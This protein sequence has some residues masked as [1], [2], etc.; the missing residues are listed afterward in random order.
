MNRIVTVLA[1]G[2]ALAGCYESTIVSDTPP[3][4]DGGMPPPPP[5]P[6]V[7]LSTPAVSGGTVLVLSSQSLAVIGDSDHGAIFVF[8]VVSSNVRHRI[9]L[10]DGEDVGRLVEDGDGRVHAVLRRTGA[11]LDLEPASGT[12]VSTRQVCAEPRGIDWDSARDELVVAC[13]SG[14]LV[15]L[16]AGGG[17][18]TRVRLI[19]PDLRDVIADGDR[20][21]VSVF[22][23]AELLTLDANLNVIARRSPSTTSLS[24]PPAPI[25]TFVPNVAWRIRRAP[26]G[27]LMV[28]QRS[29]STPIDVGRDGYAAFGECMTGVVAPAVT[30]FPPD[31]EPAPS[32]VFQM[33]GLMV[34]GAISE[35]GQLYLAAAGIR[36]E[37]FPGPAAPG[38]T[39]I[40]A[41]IVAEQCPLPFS[42]VDVA[43]VAGFDLLDDGR[44]VVLHR[45]P[46]S[47]AIEAPTLGRVAL[48]EL[49]TP[50]IGR[51]HRMFHTV[52]QV[53][54]ACASCHPEGTEDG[55]TWDFLPTGLRRTQTLVGGLGGTEPFHWNG[56]QRDMSA[57]MQATFAERMLGFF[58]PSDVDAMNRWLD[59]LEAPRG[60]VADAAALERGRAL[61]TS[62]GCAGCH[63]GEQLT[64]NANESIG[65]D[66]AF[67]VPSL[68]GVHYRAPYLHDGRA[69][70]LGDAIDLH[71]GLSLDAAARSDLLVFVRSL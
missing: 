26:G 44:A 69:P 52:T 30:V 37:A 66:G 57:I 51:G 28:H 49:G 11:V 6:P 47:I 20:Y 61:F 21:Y 27:I 38:L 55:H 70:T 17:A 65:T 35:D 7:G 67:Q 24:N 9:E 16:P 22:R 14:E 31:G 4:D 15:M 40:P 5:P 59:G 8:D 23:A 56:D 36:D 13:A 1:L 3:V 48:V 19:E 62:M 33:A 46:S 29:I 34:D 10:A 12:V 41:S 58:E 71:A 53:F 60:P 54:V 63:A 43:P 2:L 50:E 32:G 18:P 25:S 39:I 64:N 68:R 42:G 45:D